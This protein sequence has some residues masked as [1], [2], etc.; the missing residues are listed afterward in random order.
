[1]LMIKYKLTTGKVPGKP[2][3][4]IDFLNVIRL[5]V[6]FPWASKS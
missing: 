2:K 5:R 1:M 6:N 4:K 3:E